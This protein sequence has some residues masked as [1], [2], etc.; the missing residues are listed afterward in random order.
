MDYCPIFPKALSCKRGK[1]NDNW[2][3]DP[4][5]AE[6]PHSN[7]SPES[8]GVWQ[9]TSNVF[10]GPK[11]MIIKKYLI[12]HCF[13]CSRYL[14]SPKWTGN[15]LKAGAISYSLVSSLIFNTVLTPKRYSRI[16]SLISISH[17][18]WNPRPAACTEKVN[19]PHSISPGYFPHPTHFSA[20]L[21]LS[22]GKGRRAK[23]WR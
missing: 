14:D 13:I 16:D 12:E 18:D 17:I 4:G 23:I 3:C 7:Y 9:A 21:P 10:P 1:I 22:G 2:E 15:S 19:L 5:E 20:F 11:P 8:K 6:L